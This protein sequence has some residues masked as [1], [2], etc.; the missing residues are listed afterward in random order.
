[1]NREDFLETIRQQYADDIQEAYFES[2]HGYAPNRVNVEELNSRLTQLLASAKVEGLTREE[3]EELARAT[4]PDVADK[5]VI[6]GATVI[7]FPSKHVAA[8]P[9]ASLAKKAA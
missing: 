1:M 7:K 5:L 2:E 8:A 9:V 4:L 3:F 6:G